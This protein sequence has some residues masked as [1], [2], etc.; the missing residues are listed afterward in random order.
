MS[1]LTSAPRGVLANS[2]KPGFFTKLGNVLRRLCG[3]L[4]HLQASQIL[5]AS[6]RVNPRREVI[7]HN[8]TEYIFPQ[9]V[10]DTE[11]THTHG[12]AAA[13]R[14]AATNVIHDMIRSTGQTAYVIQSS[15]SDQQRGAKLV[16][17]W[18]WVK[19]I[20]S[21]VQEQT[22]GPHQTNDALVFIDTHDY[23]DETTTPCCPSPSNYMLQSSLRDILCE[24]AVPVY[25]YS[26]SPQEAGVP[27]YHDAALWFE[28]D[29]TCVTEVY[30]GG[31]Y[32]HKIWDLSAD[33]LMIHRPATC[34]KRARTVAYL[35]EKRHFDKHWQIA[36]F[37]PV[38]YWVGRDAVLANRILRGA[39]LQRFNPI[40]HVGEHDYVVFDVFGGGV[41]GTEGKRTTIAQPGGVLCA[42]VPTPVVESL[43]V[44]NSLSNSPVTLAS[45]KS[46]MREHA[47]YEDLSPLSA[48]LLTE[49]CRDAAS[50][51]PKLATVFPSEKRG[52]ENPLYANIDAFH[53]GERPV[54]TPF[55]SPITFST[56][57]SPVANLAMENA[58]ASK[59]VIA[60]QAHA[61]ALVAEAKAKGFNDDQLHRCV[62]EFVAMV[63]QDAIS[64]GHQFPLKAKSPEEVLDDKKLT[65]AKYNSLLRGANM[66]SSNRQPSSFIKAETYPKPNDPR[67]ITT[68]DDHLKVLYSG[69]MSSI[70]EVLKGAEWCGIGRSPKGVAGLVAEFCSRYNG[71][72]MT[73][74]V[75][76]TDFKRQDGHI[77]TIARALER[78]LCGAF[79]GVEDVPVL[80]E[81]WKTQFCQSVFTRSGFRYYSSFAR[82]SGSF[83]T[84]IFNTLVTA[85]CEYYAYRTLRVAGVYM[86]PVDAYSAIGPKVGDDGLTRFPD[87]EHYR[88]A[89]AHVGQ[90]VTCVAAARPGA[91]PQTVEEY[92]CFLSR[93][94]SPDVYFGD[95]CSM[96]KPDRFLDKFHLTP[97]KYRSLDPFIKLYEKAASA[98]Y[99]DSQ[100]PV[101]GALVKLVIKYSDKGVVDPTADDYGLRS[102]NSVAPVDEQYPQTL[103]GPKPTWMDTAFDLSYRGTADRGSIV[104][105]LDACDTPHDFPNI[106]SCPGF[107]LPVLPA[108]TIYA[109]PMTP[110]FGLFP[111]TVRTTGA[112]VKA[113]RAADLKELDAVTVQIQEAAKKDPFE[114]VCRN[115]LS[116]KCDRPK[117]K[118]THPTPDE[119]PACRFHL[120]GKC[121]KQGCRYSHKFDSTLGY[122][123]EGPGGTAARSPAAVTLSAN[124]PANQ[125][126][127]LVPYAATELIEA[128]SLAQ[129][130]PAVGQLATAV[131][132]LQLAHQVGGTV[133][134]GARSLGRAVGRGVRALARSTPKRARART[135]AITTMPRATAP[136]A[137]AYAFRPAP[138]RMRA[139]GVDGSIRITHQ[140]LVGQL[141]TPAAPASPASFGM[142]EFLVNPSNSVLFPWLAGFAV[143]FEKYRM[144]KIRID[145]LPHCATTTRGCSYLACNY[146]VND[147]VPVTSQAMM[148][149]YRPREA[150]VWMKNSFSLDAGRINS[151]KTFWVTPTPNT[152]DNLVYCARLLIAIQNANLTAGVSIGDII[153]SYDVTLSTPVGTSNASDAATLEG[154][155]L[156]T[157]AVPFGINAL[158]NGDATYVGSANRVLLPRV[159][160][161]LWFTTFQGTG[162]AGGET[163][164]GVGGGTHLTF[165]NDST[166]PVGAGIISNTQ[167]TSTTLSGQAT[168]FISVLTAPFDFNPLFVN[169]IG[170]V[171]ESTA[172]FV[173]LRNTSTAEA[174][175][176]SREW[177]KRAAS[178]N[179]RSVPSA[180][181]RQMSLVMDHCD[182]QRDVALA[183]NYPANRLEP[184]VVDIEDLVRPEHHDEDEYLLLD[185]LDHYREARSKAR[186]EG[187]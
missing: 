44:L 109:T 90:D 136:T 157:P 67:M 11:T 103:A 25:T 82:L 152:A 21:G 108:V 172:T 4:G 32:Q 29:G 50:G 163:V 98:F 101:I 78:A 100:T 169:G 83:E 23:L 137:I 171:T 129:L 33:N 142:N 15:R 182:I 105:W 80:E 13:T 132:G 113:A 183:M 2:A 53:D 46:V 85:F 34:F 99:S 153:V 123:G 88:L 45:V 134:R 92:V 167:S 58:G 71:L 155:A 69:Y 55:M 130:A 38:G 173:W 79:F 64:R 176:R 61:R 144:N 162:A 87:A 187:K 17:D 126:M 43:I 177:G 41:A 186:G 127:S 66:L 158:V 81:I 146:D 128:S 140:E 94:Y 20:S 5:E 91:E 7:R 35:V 141:R 48:T 36:L 19:D 114:G 118:Y 151:Q 49:Y 110:S 124:L 1:P 22:F 14:N 9:V 185:A 96:A 8:F 63:K 70:S 112:I 37:V 161:Y 24:N 16:R 26:V 10:P 145:V 27:G 125:E 156:L 77:H 47:K 135:A 57:C 159:G 18:H 184:A 131:Q 73:P 115:F 52:V 42:T 139:S 120:K 133:Y 3:C 143:R 179:A 102:Y 181:A 175:R 178:G 6:N 30:G 65:P 104:K 89:H 180:T 28:D 116:G 107:A 174:V 74:T 119:A 150:A 76:V 84:S 68:I 147:A 59:R 31:R 51:R 97:A 121:V 40:R 154:Q 95:V 165:L 166:T 62:N 111:E 56:V 72:G 54:M 164:G 148:T 12:H 168:G 160:T 86:S 39:P 117:C 138:P 75:S 93:I 106:L 170:T 60:P 122:P 149:Q